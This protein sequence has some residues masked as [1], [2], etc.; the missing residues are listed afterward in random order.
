MAVACAS[1]NVSPRRTYGTGASYG[2][3]PIHCARG[4]QPSGTSVISECP[5]HHGSLTPLDPHC[6]SATQKETVKR[7]L[8]R[9]WGSDRSGCACC[10]HTHIQAR[11]SEPFL[12]PHLR[13]LLWQ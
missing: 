8:E 7:C 1:P 13:L 5:S 11:I 3:H 6:H 4:Q 2:L 12:F 10:P 9:G